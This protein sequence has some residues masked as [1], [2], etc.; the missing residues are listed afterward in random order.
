MYQKYTISKQIT[1]EGIKKK[2]ELTFQALRRFCS[3]SKIEGVAF[4]FSF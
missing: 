3:L 1:D 4:L 2:H